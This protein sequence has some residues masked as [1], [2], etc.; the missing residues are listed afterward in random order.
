MSRPPLLVRS[1]VTGKRYR[2]AVIFLAIGLLPF[3]LWLSGFLVPPIQII[4]V[5]VGLIGYSV[6]LAANV[7]LEYPRLLL[8]GDALIISPSP[9]T[10]KRTELAGLGQAYAVHNMENGFLN[11]VLAFRTTEDEA[12][13]RAAEKYPQPPETEE[14]ELLVPIVNFVGVDTDKA[15]DLAKEINVHRGM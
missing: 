15:E 8:T 4:V 9:F 12:A 7:F 5:G 13:H 6:M 1:I 14:A 10:S 11:T 3:A 2:N